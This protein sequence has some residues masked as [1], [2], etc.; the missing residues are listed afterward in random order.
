MENSI[1][2]NRIANRKP[3]GILA[4]LILLGFI[5]CSPAATNTLVSLD[6]SQR[7]QTITGWQSSN[8]SGQLACPGFPL[9]KDRLFNLAVNELGINRITISVRAGDENH[10]DYFS[11]FLR[12]QITQ[13][14]W[15][16]HWY[17]AENDNNDPYAINPT[18]FHFSALDHEIDNVII[19]LKKA[20]EE[21]REKLYVVLLY[22]DFSHSAFEHRDYP[23]EYAELMTA[24][25]VHLKNK[26]GWVPDFIEVVLEPD[27]KARWSG[28]QV[29]EA[30]VSAGKR[31]ESK[32]FSPA[33]IAPSTTRASNALQWFDEMIQVPGVLSFLS[34]F[35]YHR[36][37]TTS[38]KDIEAIAKRALRSRKNTS[39]QERIASGHK[40]LHEDLKIGGVSAWQQF[41]LAYCTQKD[42]GAQYYRIDYTEPTNPQV[43]TAKRTK[44]LRQ[45]F[46]YIHSGAVRIGAN[47]NNKDFDPLAFINRNG[48]YVIVLQAAGAGDFTVKELP[49]GNYGVNYTTNHQSD[50]ELKTVLIQTGQSLTAH[51]PAEGVITVYGIKAIQTK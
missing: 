22:I 46:R 32:G 16:A 5:V 28:K 12:N 18:G 34:E 24:A 42:N 7:Y 20:L 49:A 39:M 44:F 37:G 50:V 4:G 41:A 19:P 8:Q 45:Y 48:S 14:E 3:G 40:E 47:S 17:T 23:E 27:G 33:F 36:Y 30:M 15:S 43:T 35:S 1:F 21:K 9:Y 29:G 25:F 13:D 10:I 11:Q 31:L 2:K 51:I 38:R 6:P 26:Y